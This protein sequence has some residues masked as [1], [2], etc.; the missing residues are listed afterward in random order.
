MATK[1]SAKQR[2]RNRR[3]AMIVVVPTFA[4]I[5]LAGTAYAYWT[6]TGS[7]SGTTATGTSTAVTVTQTGTAPS[8][9]APGG[10]AQPIAFKITNPKTT[11]QYIA[12]VTV[13]VGAITKISDGTAASGCTAS[14]FAIVQPT[15][16]NANLPTG[17][18]NY[19]PSGATI[20][21]VE[22]GQNQ[23]GCKNVNVALTFAAA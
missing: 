21:M 9:M 18:T 13:S 12:S 3:K 15:A 5:F 2:R 7:G 23:D 14:D 4:G 17:D 11:S 22:S 19:D 6:T 8:G 16:I 20:R 10:T 1:R